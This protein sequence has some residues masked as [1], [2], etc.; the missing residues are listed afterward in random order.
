MVVPWSRPFRRPAHTPAPPFAAVRE[1][2]EPRTLFAAPPPSPALN[3]APTVA[4]VIDYSLDA[5]GFFDTQ[6]KRDLLQQAADSVVKWFS[7]QLMPITPAGTDSWDAVLD[8]P[9]TGLQ[10]T[11]TNPSVG[12]NQVLLFAGGRDMTD[13]LGRGGPG[14]YQARGSAAWRDRV[15]LR[16]QSAAGGPE[17]APWGG[18][19]TFDTAPSSPWHFGQT[20]SGL[21]GANDFLSVAAHEVAHLLGFGTS[22]AW[23]DQAPGTTHRFA[24]PAS[25]ALYDG[26]GDVPLN[27]DDSH[28]ANGTRDEGQEVAM[29]PLIT[30]G[31]RHLLTPLDYAGLD[32]IGWS[33]PPRVTAVTAS[34]VTV[35]GAA[36]KQFSV[37]YSHYAAIDAAT[38]DAADVSLVAPGGAALP[39]SVASQSSAD[40]G[41][42]RTVT[43]SLAAPGGTWDAADNGTYSIVLGANQVRGTTGEA[44]A[45]GTLGVFVADVADAPVA[46]LEPVPEPA[47]RSVSHTIVVVYTDAVAV[48][49]ASIDPNDVVAVGPDGVELPVTGASVDS[50][51]PGTPRIA[52][53]TLAAPGGSWGPEDDGVYTVSLRAGEVRDLSGNVSAAAVINTFEVSLGA[54]PF[55]ARTPVTYT[56][57]S[58]DV[59]RVSLKGPGTGRVRFTAIRPADAA[60]IEISGTTAAST[61]SVRVGP[62]GTSVGNVA[63]NGSLKAFTGKT[64][65][66]AGDLAAT[67]TLGVMRLRNTASGG[68]VSAASLGSVVGAAWGADLSSGSFINKLKV[69]SLAGDVTA[70]GG[71][72]TVAA[73]SISGARIF[74]GVRPDLGD[75]L[76]LS[77]ADFVNPAA[78][79]RGVA[80]KVFTASYVAAPSIGKLSFGVGPSGGAAA[81]RIT[82]AAGR[83]SLAEPPFKL[84]NADAPGSGLVATGFEIRVL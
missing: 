11:I 71:I 30:V 6:Q 83:I 37:T 82:S 43:Y 33:M 34:S 51:A 1:P 55:D 24:G 16:G 63:V 44:A 31:T 62:A 76:P 9:A 39:A 66:L 15:A 12:A 68:V 3:V 65:D 10:Q 21:S 36:P 57:A 18:A 14:G 78:S 19:I 53:Y 35:P 32:D 77:G 48:D 58:G 38:V 7:D 20:T 70:A 40:G 72:G 29:D 81:D 22:D 73:G 80:T 42:S 61:V 5:N 59:V 79:V 67:G 26:A 2:L 17:F 25:V 13:A 50:T 56:D 60:G 52:T 8:H 27:D 84:R 47:A 28:W 74:A 69:A 54:L 4:V 45:A 23:H 64:L 49:P 75:A 41:A 46:T